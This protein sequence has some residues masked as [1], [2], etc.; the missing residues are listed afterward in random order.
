MNM[1][2]C[3]R[4]SRNCDWCSSISCADAGNIRFSDKGCWS[5]GAWGVMVTTMILIATTKL[6]DGDDEEEEE[7]EEDDD[8]MYMLYVGHNESAGCNTQQDW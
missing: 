5:W 8:G 2:V 7:E 6:H 3:S 1:A 4:I